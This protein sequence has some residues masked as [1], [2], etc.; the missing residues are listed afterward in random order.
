MNHIGISVTDINAALTWYREVLGF[1]ILVA[2]VDVIVDNSTD[3]GILL[4]HMYPPEMKRVKMAHMTAGN[5]VGFELFQFIDPPTQR[6]NT[7]S[8]EYSRAETGGKQLS[9]VLTVFPGEIYQA[10]YCL[11][12]FGNLV[13]VMATSYE[14]QMSNRDPNV[15]SQGG[16]LTLTSRSS[17]SQQHALV[18]FHIYLLTLIVFVCGLR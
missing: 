17:K 12:P 8:F 11:D 4:S 9:P 18:D 1:T 2:P 7:T 13:E 10:V 14:R 6:P 15:T 16:G 3:M 5:G